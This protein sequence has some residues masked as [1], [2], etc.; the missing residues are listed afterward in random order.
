MA[1]GEE[2]P[3]H[4]KLIARFANSG[5]ALI[6]TAAAL[7]LL[8][9]GDMGAAVAT[10][11]LALLLAFNL[12]LVEKSALLLSEEEWLKGEVRKVLL[13]RKLAR[14]SKEEA[15]DGGDKQQH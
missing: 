13:R 3:Q 15:A 4:L 7:G 10:L 12:Y 5:L 2:M 14:L 9:R 8:S 6:L 11:L 1:R